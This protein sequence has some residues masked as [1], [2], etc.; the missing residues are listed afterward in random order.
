MNEFLMFQLIDNT[1]TKPISPRSART[2]LSF[3]G[4]LALLVS[5]AQFPLFIIQTKLNRIRND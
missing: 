5:E 2:Q 4:P 1:Q 3:I